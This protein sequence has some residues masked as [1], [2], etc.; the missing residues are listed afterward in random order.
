MDIIG[1][2]YLLITSGSYR[3]NDPTPTPQKGYDTFT[4]PADLLEPPGEVCGILSLEK[5]C[6]SVPRDKSS[7]GSDTIN[8]TIPKK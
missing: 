7:S 2:S 6:A 8:S 3:V 4:Y 5:I 1:R